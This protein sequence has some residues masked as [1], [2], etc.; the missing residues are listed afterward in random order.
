[1]AKKLSEMSLEELWQLFPITLK[2]HQPIWRTW[3]E[4]ESA[5]IKAILGTSVY[6]INHIGS[7][8]IKEL[9]A[10]PTID[11]LL[12]VRQ[13]CTFHMMLKAMHTSG[14]IYDTGRITPQIPMMFKKGY[15]EQG[16]GEKVFHVHVRYPGDYDE[17]YFRDYLMKSPDTK[18][19]YQELKLGLQ[20]KYRQDRNAYTEQKSDF[21]KTCTQKARKLF[22]NRYVPKGER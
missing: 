1:M 4:E 2:T 6:R 19:A 12:E 13:N 5:L 9:I 17:L 11:I 8:G 21:I 10:K 20:E 14:Y 16:Y 3:Y 15:T 22:P 18:K 7:S